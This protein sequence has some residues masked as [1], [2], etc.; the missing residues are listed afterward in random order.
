MT[1]TDIDTAEARRR[2]MFVLCGEIFGTDE[3]ARGERHELA[4]YLL[5]RDVTT[6]KDMPDEQVKR[7]L[8]AL[9]GYQMVDVL[10]SLRPPAA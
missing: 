4:T 6:F 5:R 7:M 3:R 1:D 2:K 10:L 9:E 8:D